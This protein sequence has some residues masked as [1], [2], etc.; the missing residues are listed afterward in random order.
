MVDEAQHKSIESIYEV[1][2]NQTVFLAQNIEDIDNRFKQQT[3]SI[4]PKYKKVA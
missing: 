1:V 2:K 3:L 4:V